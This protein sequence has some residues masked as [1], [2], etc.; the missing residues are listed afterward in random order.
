MWQFLNSTV[1]GF[2][3]GF[4]SRVGVQARRSQA[5]SAHGNQIYGGNWLSEVEM[6]H[7]GPPSVL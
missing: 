2:L 4:G 3:L 1:Y 6:I 7:R 5:L